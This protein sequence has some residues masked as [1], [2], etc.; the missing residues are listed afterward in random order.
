M[1]DALFKD[2]NGSEIKA[3][4]YLASG[5]NGKVISVNGPDEMPIITLIHRNDVGKDDVVFFGKNGKHCGCDI[6]YTITPKRIK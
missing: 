4:A 1:F 5:E 2:Y 6:N 3:K